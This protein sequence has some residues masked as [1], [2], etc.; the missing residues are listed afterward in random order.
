MIGAKIATINTPIGAERLLRAITAAEEI[1]EI[2]EHPD[3]AG[4]G[5][6]DRHGQRVA[7]AT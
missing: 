2:G 4:D 3:R 5:R 7:V 1:G 6:G